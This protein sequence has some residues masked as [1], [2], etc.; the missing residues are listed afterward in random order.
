MPNQPPYS[1]Q[2]QQPYPN[3]SSTHSSIPNHSTASYPT[4]I[5]PVQRHP[6]QQNPYHPTQQFHGHQSFQY[7]QIP[8]NPS[9]Y[10]SA[11]VRPPV[12]LNAA[13]YHQGQQ[14]TSLPVQYA[15]PSYYEATG[16]P[17]ISPSFSE[18]GKF[19]EFYL[20][21][22]IRSV[23]TSFRNTLGNGSVPELRLL[24]LLQQRVFLDNFYHG[25]FHTNCLPKV[26]AQN[27]KKVQS[28][29]K[30]FRA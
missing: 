7:G 11:P 25:A 22:I 10:P 17:G 24:R 14:Y 30:I 12:S 6:Y 23:V 27:S 20:S 21:I 13:T 5:D 1:H 3:Q 2:Q 8:Y 16:P 29:M 18:P 19:C 26:S 28:I 9:P 15:P 4:F